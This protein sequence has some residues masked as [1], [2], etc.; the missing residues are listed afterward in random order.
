MMKTK[1]IHPSEAYARGVVSGEIEAGKYVQ[2]QCQATLDIWDGKSKK[3]CLNADL[4]GKI[5][6]IL[7]ILRM[8][9]GPAAGKSI[10]DSLV[11]YQFFLIDAV[12]C[13]VQRDN[14]RIRKYQ[15]ALLEIGRKNGKTF[16]VALIFFILFYTEPSYSRFFS[17]APDGQLAREIKEALEPLINENSWA[18]QDNEF[19][20]L[21]D[22]IL[23]RPTKTKYTP[24]NFSTNRMDGKEPSI[25]IADEVGALPNSYAVDAMRSGQILVRNKLG[26]VIS[27]KYPRA[28]NPFE[29]EVGYAKKVLDGITE[30]ETEFALLYEPDDIKNWSTNDDILK[31]ANPLAMEMPEVWNELLSKR[32]K[33]IEIE[34]ARE[35]F[36]TKHCNIIFQGV[37]TESYV[38]IESV[39]ACSCEKIDWKGRSV[40]VGVDLSQTNDN[41][42]VDMVSLD[43]DGNI[44][45]LP[46][47]FIPENRIEEKTA[48]EKVD[49][50][51]YIR[52]GYCI[53]CG[54]YTIDYGAVEDYVFSLEEK[55]GV[56]ICGIGYDR[57][58]AMSS[59]Q[60]WADKYAVFEV[61]QHSDTLHAP[62]KWMYECIVDRKFRF[63]TN[64]LYEINFQNARVRFDT[65]LR[66]FLD[67]KKSTG[68][69]DMIAATAD[70]VYLLQQSG[71]QNNA[72]ILKGIDALL[73]EV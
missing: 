32:K 16:D 19:K 46:M 14:K 47:C 24:L 59:A 11:G 2:K 1:K 66:M 7:K 12:L 27:T 65:T 42:S 63:E 45:S 70:A 51:R 41:T 4:R 52:D 44:I 61:R 25:F 72:R 28:D 69:I 26:F 43:D 60:K 64:P 10:Y 21:R 39:K 17:V 68:K 23:H 15:S 8:P 55:Y 37:E 40:Y 58:N 35:N 29:D 5:D 33:A 73:D 36:V 9:K 13:T 34:S 54:D 6:K 50:P 53:A 3:Y 31:Q 22:Y 56:K 62:L 48:T 49:Y 18:L 57:Y 38:P 30:D 67:K 20:I 71:M